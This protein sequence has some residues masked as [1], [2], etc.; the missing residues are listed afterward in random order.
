MAGKELAPKLVGLLI[1]VVFSTLPWSGCGKHNPV[2]MP[3]EVI[4]QRA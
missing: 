2:A 3:D 4:N 1:D